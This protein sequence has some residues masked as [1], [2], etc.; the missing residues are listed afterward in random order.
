MPVL[1]SSLRDP[2]EG[3]ANRYG[4]G[5][6]YGRGQ[7]TDPVWPLLA[8]AGLVAIGPAAAYFTALLAVEQAVVALLI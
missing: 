1:P 5:T 4:A 2:A 8:L 3:P 7:R 6:L